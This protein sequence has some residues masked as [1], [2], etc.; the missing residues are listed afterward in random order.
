MIQFHHHGFLGYLYS[1][2]RYEIVAG[3]A[4]CVLLLISLHDV[5]GQLEAIGYNRVKNYHLYWILY[6]VLLVPSP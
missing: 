6:L 3:D 5:C 1:S 2:R 4:S